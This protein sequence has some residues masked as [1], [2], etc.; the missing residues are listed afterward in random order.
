VIPVTYYVP[1]EITSPRFAFAFAKGCGGSITQDL[2]YLFPGPVA[3]FGSPPI[4]PLL[5][6]AQAESRDFYY[7]DHGYF[8]RGRFYRVTKNAYQH[9]GRGDALPDRFHA[10]GRYVAPWRTTGSHVLVCPNSAVYCRLHGFDVYAWLRQT[11]DTI[12]AHTDREIRVR[13]KKTPFPQ[14]I[15][16]DLADAWAVVVYSSAAALDALIAGIPVFVCAPFAAG[17]R[18]GLSDVRQIEAPIFP[19]DR[20]PFL[21]Q[22]ASQQWTLPEMLQGRAWRDLTEVPCAA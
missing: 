8:G 12:R 3:L 22:L 17:A 4:W 14:P 10:F 1:H 19:D 11:I 16:R 7:A 18:M 13:W 9:D 6:R 5:R 15:I 21:W 2:E 20:E